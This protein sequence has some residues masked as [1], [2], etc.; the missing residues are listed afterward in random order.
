MENVI[1]VGCDLI[2]VAANTG[3]DLYAPIAAAGTWKLR[4][5]YFTPWT[6]RTADDANYTTFSVLKGAT[7]LGAEA[8]TTSDTGNLVAGT[9]VEIV[10]TGSGK[11]LEFAQGSSI[12]FKKA[13]TGTGLALDGAFS[14]ELVQV[15]A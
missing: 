3:E 6:N 2:L 14:A 10:L 7:S 5:V 12:H 9:A 4:K 13:D 15:R 11:D 8:V 1:Q